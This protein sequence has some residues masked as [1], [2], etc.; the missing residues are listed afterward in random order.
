M[1][2]KYIDNTTMYVLFISPVRV[3]LSEIDTIVLTQIFLIS[4][5]ICVK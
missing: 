5:I 2:Y 3:N 4:K 1:F